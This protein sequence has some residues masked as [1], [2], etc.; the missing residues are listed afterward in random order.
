MISQT[1]STT[2]LGSDGVSATTIVYGY[3]TV[4]GTLP[5]AFGN[6]VFLWQ[7]ASSVVPVNL[8]PL[9]SNEVPGNSSS[10]SGT[11]G[12][13]DVTTASYLVAYAVGPRVSDIVAT[14][15]IPAGGSEPAVSFQS[16]VLASTVVPDVVAYHYTVPPGMQPQQDGDWVGIW[17]TADT[18]L[19]F[20]APPLAWAGVASNASSG[21]GSLAVQT[22][23]G[24]TYTLGYFKG[25]FAQPNPHQTPLACTTT[26]RR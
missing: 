23:N 7:T 3:S 21:S 11:F 15:F 18:S 13:L 14:V 19:L 4:P 2:T 22:T 9:A 1:Q 5:M 17:E 10:G 24:S 25:G 16:A 8:E 6:A 26:F 12:S 20:T